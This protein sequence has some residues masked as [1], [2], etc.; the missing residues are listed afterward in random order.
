MMMDWIDLPLTL[1]CALACV[2]LSACSSPNG[3]KV[4]TPECVD[5]QRQC[6][7]AHDCPDPSRS[8]CNHG[9]CEMTTRV[10]ASASDCCPG[11]KCTSLGR[12]S[13]NYTECASDTDC[14]SA[15]DRF[16]LPWDDPS[17]GRTMRCNYK[18]CE[19]DG[20]CSE[21]GQSCF[22]G[23][24]VATA[25]CGGVC[26][27]GEACVLASNTCHPAPPTACPPTLFEDVPPGA[28]VVF[29]DPNNAYD[30][31]VPSELSCAV[32]ELPPIEP[33]D[34]GRHSS[35]IINPSTSEILV[36][37]YDGTHGDLVVRAFEIGGAIRSTQWVDG[38]PSDAPIT[39][40]VNG[41]RGGV[42]AP[43]PDVGQYSAITAI[44]SGA[45]M[46]RVFVAYHGVE[47][48]SLRFV[49][50][51]EQGNYAAPHVV[52]GGA[53]RGDV[54][55]YAAIALS[56]EGQDG[57]QWPAIAY[58]QKSGGTDTVCDGLSA[59]DVDPSRLTALKFARA[60]KAVP[61]SASDW[62][63][64]SV[65]CRVLPPPPCD[66]CPQSCVADATSDNG[67][68]CLASV[69]DD[70]DGL[71]AATQLCERGICLDKVT[72]TAPVKTF[73]QGVG[74]F[75]SLAFQEGSAV[76]HIAWYDQTRGNLM[77]ST[78]EAGHWSSKL[79]DGEITSGAEAGKDTGNVGL[80]PA[81]TFDRQNGGAAVLA[82]Y[83]ATRHA[84]RYLTATLT[85]QLAPVD[86]LHPSEAEF[87][88]TGAGL[89][90]GAS[91]RVGVD[92]TLVS[93]SEGLY[94]AYQD[95][96]SSDLILRARGAGGTWR[97]LQRWS[98]GALGYYAGLGFYG[99]A[100]YAGS[101]Q[102]RLLSIRGK[103]KVAHQYKLFQHLLG[104]ATEGGDT[105]AEGAGEGSE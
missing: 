78:R 16:C 24:C 36:S 89:G 47:D 55:R 63:I 23:V 17:F 83:D 53:A 58:F 26:G 86:P 11:Q 52:D 44:R 69:T 6:S 19:R 96:T 70:C 14:G 4:D 48:R 30:A 93:T 100:L 84:L 91:S 35:L 5:G 102:F 61:A 42:S 98:D 97:Q 18:P 41:P 37:M 80:Y 21:P 46:G 38:V 27:E 51:D 49:S 62:D 57:E 40:A 72:A 13:D 34:L 74:L 76:P 15:G 12:C 95:A 75:P 29:S 39:G 60:K 7:T 54:G 81:L 101:A 33:G 103:P 28:L 85:S 3:T 32:T 68:R 94:A 92:V 73:P 79:V 99:N 9:C 65:A 1:L 25:P 50:R 82:Y 2:G 59:S 45:G 22:A 104:N 87:I 71:C 90:S 31:C 43:G 105:Q 77:I 8:S 10:C 88:D 66:G 67:T 56:T 64:E 20:T